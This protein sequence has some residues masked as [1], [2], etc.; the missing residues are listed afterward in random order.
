[1]GAP[2]TDGFGGGPSIFGI[3][4]GF[5]IQ[6]MC[7]AR[8]EFPLSFPYQPTLRMLKIDTKQ[9]GCSFF[10]DPGIFFRSPLGGRGLQ[11]SIFAPFQT[12]AVLYRNLCLTQLS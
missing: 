10:L 3:Y 1:M 2:A 6:M 9:G 7:V 11:E 8:L 12:V 5:W 4:S